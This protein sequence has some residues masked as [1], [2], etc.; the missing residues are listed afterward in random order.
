MKKKELMKLFSLTL[1]MRKTI[2]FLLIVVIN[3]LIWIDSDIRL[4]SKY[5]GKGEVKGGVIKNEIFFSLN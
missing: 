4:K 1:K 2:L 5:V 3:G